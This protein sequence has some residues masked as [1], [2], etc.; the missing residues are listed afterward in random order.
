MSIYICLSGS[1]P[2]LD[3]MWLS[4]VFFCNFTG[5]EFSFH[6]VGL[7]GFTLSFRVWIFGFIVQLGFVSS[8]STLKFLS[9]CVDLLLYF[10]SL[11]GFPPVW[12]SAQPS[13]VLPVF[14]Y[15]QHH[16]AL[17][18][19]GAPQSSLSV[20]IFVSC[21]ARWLSVVVPW[22]FFTFQF[23]THSCYLPSEFGWLFFGFPPPS[24]PAMEH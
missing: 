19:C 15:L 8:C 9:L 20:F 21:S 22:S 18:V 1:A 4:G 24:H 16:W 6:F 3:F 23:I 7:V 14:N 10:L 11:S 17:S 2:M 13:C 5:F 12:L